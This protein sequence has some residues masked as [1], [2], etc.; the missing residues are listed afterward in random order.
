MWESLLAMKK[1]G[2]IKTELPPYEILAQEVEMRGGPTLDNKQVSQCIN[3]LKA[4][5]YIRETVVFA[6]QARALSWVTA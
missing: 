4:L 2:Q 1:S 5:G 6:K 3:R